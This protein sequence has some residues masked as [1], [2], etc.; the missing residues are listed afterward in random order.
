[1]NE[2]WQ[3]VGTVGFP[4]AITTYL[5]VVFQKTLSN[6]TSAVQSLEQTLLWALKQR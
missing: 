4:V 5:I 1:M 6:L 2:V 3:A